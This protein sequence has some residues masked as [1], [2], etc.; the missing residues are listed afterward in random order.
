MLI[1]FFLVLMFKCK[2][3]IVVTGTDEWIK[4]SCTYIQTTVSITSTDCNY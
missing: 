1:F 2:T 3:K 4:T